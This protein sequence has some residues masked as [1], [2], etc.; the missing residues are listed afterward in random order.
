MK[1]ENV[2]IVSAVSAGAGAVVHQLGVKTGNTLV[3]AGIGIG[4]AL[5]GYFSNMGDI[6][7]VAEAGGIGYFLSAVL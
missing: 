1:E 3:D 7:N 2:V 6:S 4:V 5:L